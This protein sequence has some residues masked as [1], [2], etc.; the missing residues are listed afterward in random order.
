MFIKPYLNNVT[1]KPDN[2]ISFLAGGINNVLP[3]QFIAD[4]E[5]QEMNNF[6]LDKY[7][8][9]RTSVGRTMFK[10]P[11]ISG[12]EIKYFGVAG[13][14]YLFYIQNETLKDVIGNSIATGIA[15]DNFSH[16]YYKD[17]QYEYLILY[18]ENINPIRIKL[19][20]SNQNIPE[21]IPLPEEDGQT[22]YFEHMCYHKR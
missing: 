19:P 1:Y 20:L 8:A 17:G 15:G 18:G 3:G 22:I 10:N 11:G 2:V 6:S 14:N 21:I 4:D 16:T 5:V 12:Q 13:L 9:L 7:P